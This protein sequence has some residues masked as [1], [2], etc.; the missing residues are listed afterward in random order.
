MR[1]THR[2]GFSLFIICVR[3]N[4]KNRLGWGLFAENQKCFWDSVFKRKKRQQPTVQVNF[5][6]VFVD[7]RPKKRYNILDDYYEN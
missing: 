4:Q 7:K 2:Y 6:V 3:L 1:S 5:I